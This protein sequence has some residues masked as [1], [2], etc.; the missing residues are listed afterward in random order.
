MGACVGNASQK[1]PIGNR[2]NAYRDSEEKQS[3]PI[4]AG[5]RPSK[6]YKF[7]VN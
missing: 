3:S 7:D 1:A 5:V 2:E 4:R 6:T